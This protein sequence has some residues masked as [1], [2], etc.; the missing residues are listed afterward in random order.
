MH[1]QKP[2][3]PSAVSSGK[4]RCD[5]ALLL[6]YISIGQLLGGIVLSAAIGA[7]LLT[8]WGLCAIAAHGDDLA[9]TR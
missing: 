7:L 8:V 4:G 3:P 9:G 1:G 6:Q 2:T 5:M